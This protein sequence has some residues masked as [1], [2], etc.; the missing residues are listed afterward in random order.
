MSN[1]RPLCIHMYV[2]DGRRRRMASLIKANPILS[3]RTCKTLVSRLSTQS[4]ARDTNSHVVEST[5]TRKPFTGKQPSPP[6]TI[7]LSRNHQP[8]IALSRNHQ[9]SHAR[10]QSSIRCTLPTIPSHNRQPWSFEPVFVKSRRWEF[11]KAQKAS[12]AA[13]RRHFHVCVMRPFSALERGHETRTC[14][15]AELLGV[16]MYTHHTAAAD[17][18]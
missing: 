14:A 6:S 9:T 16:F 2:H 15:P 17:Q 7:A 13:P 5:Q 3:G 4:S 12:A 10:S 8:T 1:T 18:A 11:N